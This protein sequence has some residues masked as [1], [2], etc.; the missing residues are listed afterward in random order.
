MPLLK[1]PA[2]PVPRNFAPALFTSYKV[3][4]GDTLASIAK[5]HGMEVWELIYENFKTLDP[6]EANWYLKNYVGCTKET[7]DK[8]NLAFSSKD[9]PGII[10]VPVPT[11]HSPILTINSPTQSALNNVWAGIA[12]GHSA[13]LFV[14]GAFDVT[15][16]VYNLGDNA[17][18]VRNA[19]LNINGYKFG[20]GLGGSIGATLVIAYG[21]PQA[22]DMV[23]ETN[24]FDFDLAVGVKL[25]DLLKGLKGIGTALDTLDKFKKIR[26]VAEQTIKTTMNGVPE[27]KGII[28]LP[29]P[30]AGAGIHA[31][32]GFKT[33]KISVFNTGT[34]IF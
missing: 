25:G 19:V 7:N 31:W 18:N 5:A 9:K 33:G 3:K 32:A 26:Y 10:Y 4:D 2:K 17:P 1:L 28:T 22:R 16:I 13:D 8:V 24:G 29:I 21:Y 20:P 34:G 27:S 12:K 6:R 11:P 30:L 14:A 23:G 15:G